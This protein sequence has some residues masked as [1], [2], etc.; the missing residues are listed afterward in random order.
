ML[1]IAVDDRE[2]AIAGHG[3]EEVGAHRDESAR[4]AGGP[5]ETAEEFLPARLGGVVDLARC[6]SSAGR[7]EAGHRVFHPAPVGSELV[8]QRAEESA[9]VGVG[10][11]AVSSE[12]RISAIRYSSRSR[13][14]TMTKKF[15]SDLRIYSA[16]RR[17][18]SVE[19]RYRLA[20]TRRSVAAMSSM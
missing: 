9:F 14:S 7:H 1:K 19:S 6:G 12:N 10:K 16:S 5:I 18:S 2:A 4:A 13:S 3:L 17:F 11:D 20:L 15:G 8:G